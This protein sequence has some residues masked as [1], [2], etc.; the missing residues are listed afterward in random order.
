MSDEPVNPKLPDFEGS[1]KKLETIV[2]EMEKS[3]LSLEKALKQFEEGIKLARTCQ[4]ALS[5]A[6]QQV[7]I[8]VADQNKEAGE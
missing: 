5:N 6:E 3:D 1:L 4:Q 2:S 7:E 8:L